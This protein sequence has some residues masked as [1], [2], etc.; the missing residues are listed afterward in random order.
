MGLDQPLTVTAVVEPVPARF[1]VLHGPMASLSP[2]ATHPQYCDMVGDTHWKYHPYPT[3][4][5]LPKSHRYVCFLGQEM[6][7]KTSG[8]SSDTRQ[9]WWKIMVWFLLTN[10]PELLRISLILCGGRLL[11][12]HGPAN[13]S[14]QTLALRVLLFP[15]K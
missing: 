4:P 9:L 7:N 12:S 2:S 14:L 10:I 11:G 1:P 15:Y 6:A 5:P 8:S 3:P 13:V